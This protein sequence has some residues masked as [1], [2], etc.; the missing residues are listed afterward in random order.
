[1]R[2][3]D[4]E[5]YKNIRKTYIRNK[6]RLGTEKVSSSRLRDPKEREILSRLD[7]NRW[8]KWL[9]NGTLIK[10]D[11]RKYKLSI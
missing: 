2:K 4:W 1:M 3:I 6:A 10:T 9:K 8:Q 11:A 7:R 5:D